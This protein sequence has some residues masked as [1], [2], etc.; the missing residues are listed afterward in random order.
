MELEDLKELM[1]LLKDTDV[2]ELQIEKDGVKVKIKREK[3]FGHL[4]LQPAISERREVKK[5]EVVVETET[6]GRLLTV[7]SPIVGTFYRAPSPEAEPFVDFGAKVKKGQ[8]IC[9]IEAMKLMNEIESEVD[10]VV[11]RILVENGHPVEYG[12]PLFLV[13]PIG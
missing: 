7:T 3:F 11:V 2:T 10:G 5:E 8:V 9:V 13:E 12:E 1:G 6:E 4:E